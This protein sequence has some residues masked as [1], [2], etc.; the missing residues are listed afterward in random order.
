MCGWTV[1][2]ECVAAGDSPAPLCSL[3]HGFGL[4]PQPPILSGVLHQTGSNRIF[5]YVC[6]PVSK[7]FIPTENVIERLVL[8]NLAFPFEGFIYPMGRFALDRVHDLRDGK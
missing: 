2:L 5:Q 4:S 3:Q 1:W 7:A 8:P 6:H